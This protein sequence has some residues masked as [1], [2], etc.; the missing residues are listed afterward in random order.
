MLWED[1]AG[2]NPS[3]EQPLITVHDIV[4]SVP[5]TDPLS[6]PLFPYG[7]SRRIIQDP[8]KKAGERLRPVRVKRQP[9]ARGD[10]LV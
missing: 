4:P 7:G 2:F 9:D 8:A 10:F 3:F 6:G 5:L 1:G